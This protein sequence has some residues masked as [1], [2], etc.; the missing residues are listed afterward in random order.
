MLDTDTKRRIN[1]GKIGA[2]ANIV[3]AISTSG[4]RITV[5]QDRSDDQVSLDKL[6]IQQNQPLIPTHT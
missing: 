4:A 1:N 5:P 3:A 6:V 2:Y